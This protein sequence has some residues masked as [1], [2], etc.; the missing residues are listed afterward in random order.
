MAESDT[1]GKNKA[2][3][4]PLS[5][6]YFVVLTDNLEQTLL[7]RHLA[8]GCIAVLANVSYPSQRPRK[9]YT[10][11]GANKAVDLARAILFKILPMLLMH[12]QWDFEDKNRI[13]ET[14]CMFGVRWK[15]VKVVWTDRSQST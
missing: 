2:W 3:S 13:R 8:W 7:T 15:N 4:E 9:A 5:G 10:N 12:F 11:G 6:A 14:E 1:R